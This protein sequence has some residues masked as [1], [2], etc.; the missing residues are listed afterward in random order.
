MAKEWFHRKHAHILFYFLVRY[1]VKLGRPKLAVFT[2]YLG[3]KTW[4]TVVVFIET[5]GFWRSS[6]PSASNS[7]KTPG[8]NETTTGFKFLPQKHVKPP[9]SVGRVSLKPYQKKKERFPFK[10]FMFKTFIFWKN[11]KI[12]FFPSLLYFNS[13]A[14]CFCTKN[15]APA[16]RRLFKML[17]EPFPSELQ[18]ISSAWYTN[19]FCVFN[20]LL[21][22][23]LLWC[24][25]K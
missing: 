14:V 17:Y 7:A 1:S 24:W 15:V 10:T 11:C 5:G 4:N 8:F 13:T 20:S 16:A 23:F 25:P 2:C 18:I 6:R 9:I 3:I 12:F 22:S 19:C 21:K